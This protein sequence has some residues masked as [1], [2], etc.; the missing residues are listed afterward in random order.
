M[1]LQLLYIHLCFTQMIFT[2]LRFTQIHFKQLGTNHVTM[3]CQWQTLKK[4][5]A[6]GRYQLS[7][8]MRIVGP[9]QFWRGCMIYLY[10]KIKKYPPPLPRQGAFRWGSAIRK[11]SPFLGLYSRPTIS[12]KKLGFGP[13]RNTSPVLGLYSRPP[14]R[15]EKRPRSTKMRTWSLLGGGGAPGTHP[16]F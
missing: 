4:N 14:I 2:Q 7:R 16:R 6:Y 11:T 9:I 15:T 5:P 13:L 8:P 3:C 10:I 1:F 12:T